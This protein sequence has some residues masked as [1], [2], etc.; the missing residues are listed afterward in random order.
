MYHTTRVKS[1]HTAMPLDELVKIHHSPKIEKTSKT[2]D[3]LRNEVDLK[4]KD[5]PKKEEEVKN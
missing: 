3:F 4:N 2:K 1:L 5:K